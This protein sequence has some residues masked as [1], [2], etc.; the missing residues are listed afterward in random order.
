MGYVTG[1]PNGLRMLDVVSG[2]GS[3]NVV[4]VWDHANT[5]GCA[6]SNTAA[7]PTNTPPG[8]GPWPPA[9]ATAV[10]HYPARHNAT[11]C[12]FLYVDGHVVGMSPADLTTGMFYAVGP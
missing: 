2:N 12:N 11:T 8:R 4:I 1:G 6:N 5:P 7:L 10:T 3:S 9:A